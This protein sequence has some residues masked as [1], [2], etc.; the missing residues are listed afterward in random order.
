MKIPRGSESKMQAV[1]DSLERWTDTNNMS[2]NTAK[3][4]DILVDLLF[5]W[6]ALQNQKDW[7][8]W[9]LKS[10]GFRSTFKYYL[11]FG[12]RKLGCVWNNHINETVK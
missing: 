2:L 9:T 3:T 6:S 1:L 5:D 4:K 8:Y 11:V 7:N 10:R 12:N